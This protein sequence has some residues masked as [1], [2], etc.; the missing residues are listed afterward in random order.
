VFSRAVVSRVRMVATKSVGEPII[1]RL[2]AFNVEGVGGG[3]LLTDSSWPFEEGQGDTT[4][5]EPQGTGKIA[6]AKW[7]QGK[8]GFSR[9]CGS[10]AGDSEC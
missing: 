10:E 1:C 9:R 6:G 2:A 3:Q 7:T 8:S 5:A 4:R